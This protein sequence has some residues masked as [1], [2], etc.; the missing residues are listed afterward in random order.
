M[1]IQLSASLWLMNN[2]IRTLI[3]GRDCYSGRIQ[4]NDLE[5]LSK[6]RKKYY[7]LSEG[8]TFENTN[9]SLIAKHVHITN[10][11]KEKLVYSNEKKAY[12]LFSDVAN[13]LK[14]N[15]INIEI[16]KS[17]DQVFTEM[18]RTPSKDTQ[19][20]IEHAASL[21]PLFNR[22]QEAKYLC[23]KKEKTTPGQ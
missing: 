4:E 23:W 21:K 19:K 16:Y 20:A 2:E 1:A 7:E 8:S 10:I 6:L 12:R 13:I 18:E 14:N 22:H 11:Q 15:N 9:E 5:K 3:E 17:L